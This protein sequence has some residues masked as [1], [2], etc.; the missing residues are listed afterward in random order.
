MKTELDVLRNV[1]VTSRQLASLYPSVQAPNQK[2]GLLVRDGRI[3]R[4]KKGMFVVSEDENERPLSLELIANHL[5]T[6]SYVS[7]QTALRHYGLIP[8]AV[9]VIQSM[10]IKPTQSFDNALGRFTYRHMAR[11]AFGI[12][13]RMERF[14]DLSF[15]IATPEKALCDLIAASPGVNLRYLSDVK[16]YLEEDLRLDMEAFSRF[17]IRIL[18]DYATVGQKSTS[19][20][21]LIKFLAQ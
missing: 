7:L 1:P 3:I 10:T 6:P 16:G 14:G 17:D 20:K 21:T 4:L 5:C 13:V 2:I 11:E 18:S 15:T 9:H 19:I 12:G 8:E